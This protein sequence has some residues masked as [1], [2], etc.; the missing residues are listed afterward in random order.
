MWK[1]LAAISTMFFFSQ[2]PALATEILP[3]AQIQVR[4]DETIDVSHWDRGRI[5]PAHV[6]SD[7]FGRGGDVAIHRGARAELI[8]RQ[9]GPGEYALDLE[10][11]TEDG[12]RYVMDTSGPQYNMQQQQH[13][14]GNGF[15]G[16]IAGAIA[17]ANGE[18]VRPRGAEIHVPAGSAITFNLQ[19][20]LHVATWGDPGYQQGGWHY[21]HDQD[22]YR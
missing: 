21:H 18:Q 2:I 20:P 22:W 8:V 3:G 5:Y 14:N 6:V 11:I 15:L 7:V 16:A 13:N 10:S 12:H 1:S 19:E 17:G 9:T 4:A